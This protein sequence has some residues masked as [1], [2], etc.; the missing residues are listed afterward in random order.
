MK[1]LLF[2]LALTIA[3]T[4]KAQPDKKLNEA[5]MKIMIAY[6]DNFVSISTG[7]YDSLLEKYRS[8]VSIE[9]AL[10]INI[11]RENNETR[12]FV[13]AVIDIPDEYTTEQYKKVFADWASKIEKL[14]L[15][16]AKLK[17]LKDDRYND[18]DWYVL[19]KAWQFDNSRNNIA[20]NYST[21]TI[22]LEL[23]DLDMGGWQLE[24]IVG[25]QDIDTRD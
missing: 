8:S 17:E 2:L 3:I 15:N 7:N 24:L 14:D 11:H 19:G 6:P 13:E 12:R 25:H 23:L 20:P 9:G 5:F 16:G 21:F 10:Y 22:R 1:P 18:K 4:T